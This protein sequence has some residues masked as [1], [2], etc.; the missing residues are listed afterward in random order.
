MTSKDAGNHPLL[1]EL[2]GNVRSEGGALVL[3]A[4]AVQGTEKQ[5]LAIERGEELFDLIRELAYLAGFLESAHNDRRGAEAV[6]ALVM[7]LADRLDALARKDA[8]PLQ[9]HARAARE[10]AHKMRPSDALANA[11]KGLAAPVVHGASVRQKW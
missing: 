4:A 3:P 1:E 5:A 11:A 9:E 6:T 8:G 10:L 2:L 7:R